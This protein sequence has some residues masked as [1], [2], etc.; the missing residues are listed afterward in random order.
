MAL[1]SQY[2]DRLPLSVLDVRNEDLVAD[3][4]GQT[5]RLC[6][7]LG[8]AF[9]DSMRGFAGSA[10]ARQIATPSAIQVL[11]GISGEGVGHWRNY[12][13]QLEPVL[14]ILAPWV[15]RFGYV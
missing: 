10:A 12:Q 13:G 8:L 3:F 9:E 15:E 7:F 2:R 6:D 11:K 5:R 4:D 1:A 14:P